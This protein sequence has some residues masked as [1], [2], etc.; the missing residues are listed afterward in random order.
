MRTRRARKQPRKCAFRSGGNLSKEHVWPSLAA[1]LLPDALGRDETLLLEDG[2]PATT[3][4][5][6]RSGRC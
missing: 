2:P 5:L 3:E 1:L 4:A 6:S